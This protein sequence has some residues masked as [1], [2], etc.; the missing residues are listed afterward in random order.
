[1]RISASRHQTPRPPHA[2]AGTTAGQFGTPDAAVG[3]ENTTSIGFGG[4]TSTSSAT[5]GSSAGGQL[6]QAGNDINLV[7]TDLASGGDTIL[8]AANDIS[9]SALQETSS[10]FGVGVSSTVGV[11]ADR[12]V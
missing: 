4:G 3:V 7:G 6:S 1:M 10:S 2:T 8:Q 12:A 11:R 5:S 9:I